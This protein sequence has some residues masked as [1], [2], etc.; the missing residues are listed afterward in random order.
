MTQKKE[1]LGKTGLITLK[2]FISDFVQESEPEEAPT[3]ILEDLTLKRILTDSMINVSQNI[4]KSPRMLDT[5]RG[6]RPSTSVIGEVSNN[7]S[8]L[9]SRS[10]RGHKRTRSNLDDLTLQNLKKIGVVEGGKAKIKEIVL[11]GEN[12]D[13]VQNDQDLSF[14]AGKSRTRS[15]SPI[16]GIKIMTKMTKDE[17]ELDCQDTEEYTITVNRS[18]TAAPSRNPHKKYIPNDLPATETPKK[19]TNVKKKQ[20]ISKT[21]QNIG[22]RNFMKKT[23]AGNFT[24]GNE[25]QSS[26]QVTVN[27]EHDAKTASFFGN[28]E[29]EAQFLPIQK[30]LKVPRINIEKLSGGIKNEGET[31][32]RKGYLTTTE[33]AKETKSMATVYQENLV[34]EFGSVYSKTNKSMKSMNYFKAFGEGASSAVMSMDIG[35]IN[36]KKKNVKKENKGKNNEGKISAR[37]KFEKMNSEREFDCTISEIHSEPLDQTKEILD[38]MNINQTFDVGR[39]KNIQK[40]FEEEFYCHSGRTQKSKMS[41][42]SKISN[43]PKTVDKAIKEMSQS[44]S[45]KIDPPKTKSS[46]NSHNKLAQINVVDLNQSKSSNQ[47]LEYVLQ[48]EAEEQSQAESNS[49]ETMKTTPKKPK[50][51][52]SRI[53]EE[54]LVKIRKMDIFSRQAL[55]TNPFKKGDNDQFSKIKETGKTSVARSKTAKKLQRESKRLKLNFSKNKKIS[56]ADSKGLSKSGNIVYKGGIPPLYSRKRD[57]ER[58]VR[59]RVVGESQASETDSERSYVVVESLTGLPS[60]KER[61]KGYYAVR[62]TAAKSGSKGAKSGRYTAGY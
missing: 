32:D 20:E 21:E 26:L 56:K 59:Q 11:R 61:S 57:E 46:K 24:V 4:P 22:N 34:E 31:T 5:P 13:P 62:S 7:R 18:S 42:K 44:V 27:V 28:E 1:I 17:E 51:R 8:L 47:I 3:Q 14:G 30:G 6:H 41:K 38:I 54:E 29:N 19:S 53:L 50:K 58:T 43:S 45:L 35:K 36:F 9:V 52:F 48:K 25:N 12:E 23:E 10:S 16:S 49:T 33:R 39:E 40:F 37:E 55:I 60:G 2:K 15:L